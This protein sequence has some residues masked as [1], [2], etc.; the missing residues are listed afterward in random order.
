MG[1]LPISMDKQEIKRLFTKY[2]EIT[3]DTK[4]IIIAIADL[5]NK[6]ERSRRRS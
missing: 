5:G 1:T 3:Q 4:A 6:I 2:P